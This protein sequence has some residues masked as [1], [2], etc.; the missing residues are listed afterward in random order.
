MNIQSQKKEKAIMAGFLFFI[1]LVL[2]GDAVSFEKIRVFGMVLSPYRIIIPCLSIFLFGFRIYHKK[3]KAIFKEKLLVCYMAMMMFWIVWGTILLAFS[4]YCNVHNAI[5][6]LLALILGMGGIY[7][8]FELCQSEKRWDAIIKFLRITAVVLCVWSMVEILAGVYFPTSS[9][10]WGGAVER[11]DWMKF[12]LSRLGTDSVYLTTTF[13]F[14]VNDYSAFLA[15]FLPLFYLDENR[16]RRENIGRGVMLFLITFILSVNDSNIVIIAIFL[17]M[18]IYTVMKNG[19]RKFAGGMLGIL[20]AWYAIGSQLLC[21]FLI[22]VKSALPIVD[23]GIL[24]KYED[25]LFLLGRDK[26]ALLGEVVNAQLANAANGAGSLYVRIMI[27]ISSLKM[28]LKTKLM[29]VGPAGFTN[30][31]KRH[32]KDSKLLDPHN[33]WMEIMAQYGVIVFVLY[34]LCTA[35]ICIKIYLLYRQNGERRLLLF[36]CVALT[37]CIACVAPSSF[38]KFSYQWL[39]PSVGI[40]LLKY[41]SAWHRNETSEKRP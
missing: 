26:L 27:T 32:E 33:W 22:A 8:F 41:S 9:R 11:A 6:E 13:F 35:V 18:I 3:L 30:Y 28:T 1:F 4:S 37:F 17:S 19:S 7:C 10:Y 15:L 39:I 5:K 25:I 23:Q 24:K 36:L 14:N 29:G 38:L 16:S 34:F 40:V 20:V 12:M 21:S 31:I 2:V